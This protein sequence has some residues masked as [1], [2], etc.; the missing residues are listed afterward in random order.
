MCA[1]TWAMRMMVSGSPLASPSRT[2][3]TSYCAALERR[4]RTDPET[5]NMRSLI[6]EVPYDSESIEGRGA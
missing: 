1:E 4:L 6:K 2:P 3:G 5:P